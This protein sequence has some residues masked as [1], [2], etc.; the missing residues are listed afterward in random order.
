MSS[1]EKETLVKRLLVSNVSVRNIIWTIRNKFGTG[2]STTRVLE[3]K[4][5]LTPDEVATIRAQIQEEKKQ[6]D[7]NTNHIIQTL[8]TESARQK[9]AIHQLLQLFTVCATQLRAKTPIDKSFWNTKIK[10][11]LD[12]PLI[13][14]F[15]E[16]QS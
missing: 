3:L 7:C 5:A 13:D 15:Q 12:L 9:N 10:E 1:E 4:E 14:S 8:Q 11:I 6:T 2:I 16:E